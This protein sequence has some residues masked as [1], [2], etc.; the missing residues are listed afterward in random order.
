MSEKICTLNPSHNNFKF[1]CEKCDYGC[2]KSF[3]FA[4]HQKTQKHQKEKCSK[5]LKKNMQEHKCSCG[6]IYRHIQSY[7]RHL[8][9]CTTILSSST[10]KEKDDLQ[11]TITTLITQ[12]QNI[13]ME[14]KEMREMVKDMIP[15][16]GNN[17]TTINNKFNLQ[18]FLNEQCKDAIN[19]TD[20]VET[21][22]LELA[23]LEQT[24][25]NGYIT[26]ITNIFVRGLKE[27]ELHKRPLH[28]SDLKR[29]VLYVKDNDTWE[30]DNS[31]KKMMKQAINTVAKR[32]IDTIK[33]W[34]A[35]NP[36]W[37]KTEAGTKMY[38][39]MVKNVTDTGEDDKNDNK[40]IKTIAK[41][42]IIE[43]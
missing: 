42:V 12:N 7:N 21:L 5:M 37:N 20:F 6:R 30:R 16:I 43:K 32:Q 33:E 34:E 18:F 19:L 39:D 1:Y 38:I 14:N 8:K 13:L 25:Q 27:L 3:L 26:G 35:S 15:K 41:E 11:K 4:Q 23:D 31:D 36:D 2:H 40:I 10:D 17:N 9:N 24:R 29:E 22:Q 28:C